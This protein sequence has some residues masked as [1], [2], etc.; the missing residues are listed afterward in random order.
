MVVIKKIL[1]T[2]AYFGGINFNFYNTNLVLAELKKKAPKNFFCREISDIGCGDGVNTL[3]VAKALESKKVIGYE[4]EPALIKTA[5]KKGLEVIKIGVDTV[6]SG[7]LGIL[8]GVVHHF[9]N[10]VEEMYRIIKN[11]RSFIIRE[12]I[13]KWRVFEAGKRYSEKEMTEMVKVVAKRCH[14]KIN[15]VVVNKGK[16]VLYFIG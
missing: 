3:K 12:P 15:K 2:I 7:D 4:I 14:Q 13:D 8:W 9:D 10:P 16:S 11:F 1:T 6:I 5:Q